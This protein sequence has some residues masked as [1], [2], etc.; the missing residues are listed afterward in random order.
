MRASLLFL[1][2]FAISGI[3][4]AQSEPRSLDLADPSTLES[5]PTCISQCE[6]VYSDCRTQCGEETVRARAE[7]LDLSDDAHG[8]CLG[9]C[10]SDLGLC[11]Q[12]CG[13][14]SGN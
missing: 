13:Q 5:D 3:L 14:G 12:S 9:R 4:F 6:T 1:G 8:A 7:H 11:K 2:M 10:R